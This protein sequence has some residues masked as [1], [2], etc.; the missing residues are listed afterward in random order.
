MATVTD[1]ANAAA[2]VSAGYKQ[3]QTS[4]PSK[5][6][7]RQAESTVYVTRFEK[8]LQGDNGAAPFMLSAVGE[9]TVSAGAA[10]T[11]ALSALNAIRRHRYAGAP[12]KPSGATVGDFPKGKTP[13]VDI[14]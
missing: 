4:F 6:K 8:Q 5:Q 13:T 2:A 3:I 10:D 7:G 12:G 9:S 14:H 1:L 11:A